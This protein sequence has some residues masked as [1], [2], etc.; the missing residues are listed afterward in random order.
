MMNF[1]QVLQILKGAEKRKEFLEINLLE[2]AR[3]GEDVK[4]IVTE[5]EK[6][7]K[8][9]KVL[10]NYDMTKYDYKEFYQ[11]LENISELN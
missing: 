3:K 7:E 8:A 6:I 5:L 2:Y 9:I 4:L 10:E 11:V 1:K